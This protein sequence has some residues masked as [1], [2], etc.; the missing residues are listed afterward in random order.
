MVDVF[1]KGKFMLLALCEIQK[2]K[3]EEFSWCWVNGVSMGVQEIERA[4]EGVAV[5]MTDIWHSVLVELH[6]LVP[7]SY[8]LRQFLKSICRN[9]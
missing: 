9:R 5:L 3:N 2:K 1:R 7:E 4:R 6:V 8:G